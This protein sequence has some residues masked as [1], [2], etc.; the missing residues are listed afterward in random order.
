MTKQSQDAILDK[1]SSSDYEGAIALIKSHPCVEELNFL[2]LPLVMAAVMMKQ[3]KLVETIL[4]LGVNP[5]ILLQ[6]DSYGKIEEEDDAT[7]ELTDKMMDELKELGNKTPIHIAVNS[8]SMDIVKLLINAGANVNQH[9]LGQCTPLHWAC[10]KGDLKMAEL[11]LQSG[12]NP[13]A[14][15]LAYSTPLHEAVRK[16]HLSMTRLLLK[17]DAKFDVPDLSGSTALDAAIDKPHIHQELLF[18]S[19]NLENV[20]YHS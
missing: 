8:G 12:A 16:N 1:L 7:V 2:G 20:V 5:N 10:V 13:N 15:D 3:Y 4:N 19:P 18:I 17:Y 6:P 14:Q 11:L 9:D